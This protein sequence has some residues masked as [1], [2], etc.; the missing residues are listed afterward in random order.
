MEALTVI[1]SEIT[2]HPHFRCFLLSFFLFP[3]IVNTVLQ[4]D[5]EEKRNKRRMRQEASGSRAL[6]KENKRRHSLVSLLPPHTVGAGNTGIEFEGSKEFTRKDILD[7][8]EKN[9]ALV[10]S[11]RHRKKG[12]DFIK[13]TSAP[14]LIPR[15]HSFVPVENILEGLGASPS[16]LR[17]INENNH[18]N[19]NGLHHNNDLSNG[20]ENAQNHPNENNSSSNNGN[21]EGIHND[22]NG[23]YSS[24]RHAGVGLTISGGG[25]SS[26]TSSLPTPTPT[27]RDKD[28]EKDKEKEKGSMRAAASSAGMSIPIPPSQLN[29]ASAPSLLSPNGAPPSSSLFKAHSVSDSDDDDGDSDSESDSNGDGDDRSHA[30]TMTGTASSVSLIYKPNIKVL[31]YLHGTSETSCALSTSSFVMSKHHH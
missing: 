6:L 30:S 5:V 28:K 23:S 3:S 2:F 14:V 27:P 19:G 8:P 24:N 7:S 17:N 21:Y 1:A 9:G 13:L 18:K 31:Q 10:K 25:S 11:R 20:D 22:R 16:A 4:H 12:K 15:E 29:S 26:N